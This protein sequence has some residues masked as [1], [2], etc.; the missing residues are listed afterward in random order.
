[1][2]VLQGHESVLHPISSM[3]NDV[4]DALAA[5]T[6]I[7]VQ[8]TLEAGDVTLQSLKANTAVSGSSSCSIHD[9]LSTDGRDA[10]SS[11]AGHKPTRRGGHK[12]QRAKLLRWQRAAEREAAITRAA[13]AAKA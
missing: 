13:E 10:R 11:L 4:Q 7:D 6:L 2:S 8:A 12:K 1:M 5:P 3:L 9:D